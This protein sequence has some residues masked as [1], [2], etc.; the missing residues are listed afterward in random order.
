MS[1][2]E[3]RGLCKSFGNGVRA[4]ADCNLSVSSGE[5]LVI[6]GPSGCGKTTLLRLIAGLES[7]TAGSVRIGGVAVNA[8]PPWLRDVSMVFQRPALFPNRT[9]MDNLR[10]GLDLREPRRWKFF[11]RPKTYL[12]SQVIMETAKLLRI[13]E[14]LNRHPSELSS[15]QQQRVAL[16][17]ALVRKSSVGLLDEPF[18]NLDAPL[19][20]RFLEELP[21][22]RDRFPTTMIIV[23]HDPVEAFRLGD[24]MAVMQNGI[25]LQVGLP[26]D[27]RENPVNDFVAD[28]FCGTS[29]DGKR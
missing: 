22:L 6:V 15:G 28:F 27:V 23:T 25:I 9:V 12:H 24:R 8:V 29:G 26:E 2:V 4:L 7:P 18:S 13:D 21:L 20:R 10:F 3:L 5:W 19:R 11:L 17:R 1:R 16:G 14:L